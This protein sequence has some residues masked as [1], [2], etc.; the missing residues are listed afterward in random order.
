M[1]NL[2]FVHND[3]FIGIY[4]CLNLSYFSSLDT[5]YKIKLFIFEVRIGNII[6]HDSHSISAIPWKGITVYPRSEDPD[7]T[8]HRVDKYSRELKSSLRSR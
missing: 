1:L 3:F 8:K 6:S 7:E 4:Y 2:T 5:Q